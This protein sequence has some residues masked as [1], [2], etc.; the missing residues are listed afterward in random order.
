MDLDD[1]VN[2]AS[3]ADRDFQLLLFPLRR[4]S[5]A[6]STPIAHEKV[7]LSSTEKESSGA[8]ECL[9]TPSSLQ[10]PGSGVEEAAVEG[11][12]EEEE[13]LDALAAQVPFPPP[14]PPRLHTVLH[15]DAAP[16]FQ[17]PAF[18]LPPIPP[19]G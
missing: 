6:C 2:E 19:G 4:R 8:G 1:D 13:T 15:T 16:N 7:A 14:F 11:M 17:F 5:V 12:E 3:S 9:P 10:S 18:T